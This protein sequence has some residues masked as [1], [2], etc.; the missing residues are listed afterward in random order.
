MGVLKGETFF[1]VFR[2]ITGL[3][4]EITSSRGWKTQLYLS[5]FVINKNVPRAVVLQVGELQ[6]VGGADLGWLE[7]CIQE[8]DLHYR[9]WLSGLQKVKKSKVAFF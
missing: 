3:Q 2:S 6:A 7:C 8:T 4:R 1:Y 5:I 9:F